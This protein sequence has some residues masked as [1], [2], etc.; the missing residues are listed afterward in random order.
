MEYVIKPSG[1]WTKEKCQEEALKYKCRVDF[2]KNSRPQYSE[3]YKKNWLDEICSHMKY[4]NHPNGYWT[5]ERCKELTSQYK[6]LQK[7]REEH[8]ALAQILRNNK[9]TELCDHMSSI[10]NPNGYWAYER[11]KEEALKYKN[12]RDFLTEC[13]GAY[14]KI[15]NEEWNELLSHMERLTT[16]INRY[17]YAFE[18]EDNHVYVGLTCVLNKR[19][20]THL[21][22]DRS[23]VKQHIKKT[24]SLFTHKLIT[25][26]SINL[27]DASQLEI[28]TIKKYKDAGWKLLNKAKG[29]GLGGM[30]AYWSYEKCKEAALKINK[31]SDYKKT[32]K[33]VTVIIKKNGWE[34]ELTSHMIKDIRLPGYWTYEKCVEE[35]LKYIRKSDFLKYSPLVAKAARSHGWYEEITKHMSMTRSYWTYWT[36]E[37]CKEEALKYKTKTEFNVKA[38]GAV[39][40]ARKNGWHDEI[41]SHM[42][43]VNLYWTYERCKEEALKYKTITEF[44]NGSRGAYNSVYING[45]SN[46]CSHMIDGRT[47]RRCYWTYER[48]KEEAL[49]YKTRW[50][51]KKR[52]SGA[53]NAAHLNGWFNEICSHM[54]L[55][56]YRKKNPISG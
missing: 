1:Y 32:L 16:I 29:G 28:N 24:G 15:K 23:A 53:Y 8:H 52:K 11:C 47:I 21:T 3:A 20:N 10:R 9:W 2:Q 55:N 39:M 4:V 31:L 48:C 6:D 45:W 18:F 13:E 17:I 34:D 30:R 54:P 25:K 49:K 37:R 56:V 36:Y 35:S 33:H 46:V 38:P 41:T 44:I 43:N 42:I 27:R 26:T 22:D 40:S 51:F 14:R 7:F 5:Y 19:Y 50:E 12:R